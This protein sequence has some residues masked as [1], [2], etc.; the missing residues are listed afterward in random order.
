[1]SVFVFIGPTLSIAE[2]ESELEATYLAPVSEGD[3]YRASLTR[4]QAIGIVDGY[5]ERVPAV[6][7]KEL[8]WAMEQGIRVYGSASMG[9]LRAAELAP[10]GMEGVGWVFEAFRDGLLERD[11][12]V[13]V[14]H[15]S[16]EAGYAATSEA[17]VNIRRT[18]AS[19][20]AAGIASA[21]T[22]RAL[23]EIAKVSFY[24][25]RSW[26][27]TMR[28][29]AD[30]GVPEAE[31]SGLRAWLPQGRI[32]QKR[33]DA[34]AMLRLMR[35]HAAEGA[36]PKRVRYR[37][38][39]TVAWNNARW[40]ALH[41][42]GPLRDSSDMLLVGEVLDELGLAG[43]EASRRARDGGLLRLLALRESAREGIVP[44]ERSLDEAAASFRIDRG[45]D[46]P[47]RLARWLGESDLDAEAFRSFVDAE[48]KLRWVETRGGVEASSMLLDRLRATGEY[49]GIV[50]R[51]RRKKRWLARHGMEYAEPADL[52]S[53]E[54]EIMCWYFQH[55]LGVQVPHDL[56]AHAR[57]AGFSGASSFRR[58]VLREYSY[59]TLAEEEPD[60]ARRPGPGGQA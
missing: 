19:A 54:R 57:A 11:D 12:E 49:H 8:L 51:A 41:A 20:E 55:R 45:L 29:A 47:A 34:L 5:F 37:T 31:L 3:V 35:Q 39:N 17:M 52:G 15:A 16:G 40:G 33:D 21:T 28:A 1:M 53:T 24:P 36:V 43:V 23:V 30:Q 6:W 22:A 56:D 27:A 18:L 48:A 42:D 13:A 9:A 50:Q 44:D 14:A 10:F 26:A 32:D 38:A 4:P 59:A 7:H 2:A 58:A 25:D 60:V 46:D